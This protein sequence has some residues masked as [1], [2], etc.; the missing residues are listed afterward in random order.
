M[1]YGTLDAFAYF[2]EMSRMSRCSV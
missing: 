1:Q 2:M